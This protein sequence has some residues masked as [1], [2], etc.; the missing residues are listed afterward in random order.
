MSDLQIL[1][2]VRSHLLKEEVVPRVYLALPPQ[3]IYPLILVELEEIWSSY[4][5]PGNNKSIEARI[6]FKI[7]IYSQS[8]GME[9][10]ALLSAKV[11][12]TLEGVTLLY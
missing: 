3:A 1:T 8:P 11:R 7:S 10:A 4:P 5:I 9:E 2:A 6:K 12:K